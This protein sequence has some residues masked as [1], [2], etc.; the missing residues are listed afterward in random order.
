MYESYIKERFIKLQDTDFDYLIVARRIRSDMEISKAIG[1]IPADN[2]PWWNNGESPY[3]DGEPP[4][5]SVDTAID[6][7]RK[8]GWS[9]VEFYDLYSPFE[10]SLVKNVELKKLSS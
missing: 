9:T 1:T 5:D 2:E 4:W 3:D 8:K 6:Y 7:C 10:D